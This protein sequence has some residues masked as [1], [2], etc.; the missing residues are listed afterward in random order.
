MTTG[1]DIQ[2]CIVLI[3]ACVPMTLSSVY[4]EIALGETELDPM[5][6]NG[7][8][9]VF[10]LIFACFLC[11]PATLVSDPPVPIPDLPSNLYDGLKCFV[12][13]DS[14]TCAPGQDDGE[15][16]PD[17][18][19][20]QG[21]LFVTFYLVFNQLYN[22][23]ILLLIKYGSS[24]LLWLALT[25]MVPLG[26]VTFTLPFVPE[27]QPLQ[28]T[29]IIG[30]IL[31]C[32]GLGCYR[33]AAGMYEKY[34][35]KSLNPSDLS[36]SDLRNDKS[37]LSP[38]LEEEEKTPLTAGRTNSSSHHSQHHISLKAVP[39]TAEEGDTDEL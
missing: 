14:K 7:W 8:I 27:K 37:I 6:L 23:L 15:C 9:A 21:P 30:L 39:E 19:N 11:V 29:D 20:P 13:I 34:Y 28:A 35:G 36:A 12:G 22:L 32:G 2:W 16:Y 1:G 31:I 38:F 26:N 18:C 33:F 17:D 24:N 4:K 10:Q 25:L 3:L 5:Y